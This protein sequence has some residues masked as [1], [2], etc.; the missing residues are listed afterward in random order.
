MLMMI[1]L[2]AVPAAVYAAIYLDTAAHPRA[3]TVLT[4][5]F[6]LALIGVVTARDATLI[7][8]AWELMTLVPAAA[9][10]VAGGAHGAGAERRTVFEYLAITHIGGAGVWVAVLLL[11][12]HGALGDPAGLASAGAGRPDARRRRRADRLRHQGR[13]RPAPLLAAARPPARPEQHLGGHVGRDGEG[14]ALRHGPPADGVARIARGLGRVRRARA[15]R[16]LGALGHRPGPLPARPQAPAR[17]LDD[18]ERRHRHAGPRRRRDPGRA[19]R[20]GL[21][22]PRA[23]GGPAARPQPR[24]RQG[25]PLPGRRLARAR[26][27]RPRPR[28]HG[29][30]AAAHAVDRRRRADGLPGHRRAAGAERLR[31]GVGRPAGAARPGAPGRRG[32]R[33][34]PAAW[35]PPPSRRRSGWARS[36]S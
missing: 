6:P 17:L 8:G 23:G 3:L 36:A 27:R 32:R 14:R 31:L 30:P 13:A 21:G 28:P 7:L 35:R 26:R 18:R 16:R 25:P 20:G 15:R 24:R 19:R 11:A 4:G 33:A 12:E 29:R 10:L 9:I 1:A 5:L 2:V 34:R 22:R